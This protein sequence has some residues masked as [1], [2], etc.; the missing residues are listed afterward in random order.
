MENLNAHAVDR[1]YLP[2]ADAAATLHGAIR[3]TLATLR[4]WHA[5]ARARRHLS[6]LDDRMLADI[7]LRRADV[8]KRF[9]QT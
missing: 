4:S 8:T 2:H 6:T 7:G 3:R 9:W 5:R 1:R